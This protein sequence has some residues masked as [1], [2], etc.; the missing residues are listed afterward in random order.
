MARYL[1]PEWFAA[2]QAAADAVVVPDNG[3]G[4]PLVLRQVI[5]GGPDGD[6]T[7]RLVIGAG[8][9]AVEPGDGPADLTL[10]Q[11]YPTA[12]ALLR[13]ELSAPAAFMTGRVR[14]S[15]NL[16]ALLAQQ[17]ALEALQGAFDRV[18]DL[19]DFG[20]ASPPSPA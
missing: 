7:Y 15:G 2:V 13:G 5:T 18:R 20:S 17:P 10:T 16:G 3:D 1:S 9:V 14:V 19:T 12:V 8:S 11:D 4:A 6:V